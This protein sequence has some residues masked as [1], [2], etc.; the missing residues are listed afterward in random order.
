MEER[1]HVRPVGG[2]QAL[3]PRRGGQRL[4]GAVERDH[5]DRR[6]AGEDAPRRFGIDVE[7]VF[8][9]GADVAALGE[10][11]A[12]QHDA[13]QPRRQPRLA[14]QRQR[15]I[16]QRRQAAHR[17]RVR[18][19]RHDE[20]DDRVGG[21][22]GRRAAVS[23]RAARSPRS[24]SRRGRIRRFRARGKAARQRRRRPAARCGRPAPA[25]S[26]RSWWSAPTARCRRRW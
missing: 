1:L 7:V 12:H 21:E 3:Q 9:A 17:H 25:P 22:P 15:E 26:A 11:A 8:G 2:A 18:R 19:P 10:G 24:R 14:R 16:G 20:I 13:F 6:A 5:D 23:A 4:V